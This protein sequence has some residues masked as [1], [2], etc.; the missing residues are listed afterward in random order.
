MENQQNQCLRYDT[1]CKD[2]NY[3]TMYEWA[4]TLRF[5]RKLVDKLRV[6][7][8]NNRRHREIIAKITITTK[9]I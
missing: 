8:K 9:Y 1:E 3:K 2:C 5:C 4:D 7:L 6:E